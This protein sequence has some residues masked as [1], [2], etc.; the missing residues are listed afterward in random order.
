MAYGGSAPTPRVT[1]CV[2]KKSPK[3]H[4]EGETLSMGF[5]PRDPLFRDDTKGDACPPLESPA[6]EEIC[7]EF[8][9]VLPRLRYKKNISA[10]ANRNMYPINRAGGRSIADRQTID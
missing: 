10:S 7:P 3:N 4:T 8:L 6:Y 2:D 1:F 5:L 9:R